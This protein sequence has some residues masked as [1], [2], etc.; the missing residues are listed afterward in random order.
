MPQTSLNHSILKLAIPNI[1]S[2]ITVPLL[3]FV[4]MMLMGQTDGGA[5]G[6]TH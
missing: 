5:Q 3:G 6:A 1:I 2:N 4:D